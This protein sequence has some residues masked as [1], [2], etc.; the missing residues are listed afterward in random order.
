MGGISAWFSMG[1]V[2]AEKRRQKKKIKQLE[3]DLETA[4]E[5]RE[6]TPIIQPNPSKETTH[7]SVLIERQ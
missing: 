5:V 4:L 2:R 1:A 3:K 7:Q 6:E